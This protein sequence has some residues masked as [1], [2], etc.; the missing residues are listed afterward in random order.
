MHALSLQVAECLQW[1]CRRPL[2]RSLA[3]HFLW[4]AKD[5]GMAVPNLARLHTLSWRVHSALEE[6]QPGPSP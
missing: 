5:R 2:Q 4:L 6:V 3:E 1:L